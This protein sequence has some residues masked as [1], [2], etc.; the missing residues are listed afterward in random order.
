[1]ATI[2]PGIARGIFLS[3]NV[4][5]ARIYKSGKVPVGKISDSF[6]FAIRQETFPD[7]QVT[8]W[9]SMFFSM[10]SLRSCVDKFVRQNSGILKL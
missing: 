6:N 2:A 8:I 4:P 7:R 5:R 3:E 10:T 9:I 1:M